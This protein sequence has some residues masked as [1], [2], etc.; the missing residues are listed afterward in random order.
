MFRLL[1]WMYARLARVE[2]REVAREFGEA[3]TGY[4]AKTLRSIP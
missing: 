3:Y 2:E 1:V 4:A